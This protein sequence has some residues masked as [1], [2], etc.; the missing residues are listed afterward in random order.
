[1]TFTNPSTN[2]F[3][4][5]LIGNLSGKHLLKHKFYQAWSEGSLSVPTL[6]LYAQQYYHH[7]KAF[8]RY[9]SATHS[10]C[11]NIEA[12][13]FLLENL[14]DEEK[15]TEH[16]PELWLRFAEG[17]GTTR[18]QVKN[19]LPLPETQDLVDTFFSSCRK[20]YA[21]GLGT[22]FAY[23]HQIP[24][25][26]TFKIEALQKHYG[27]EE[28]S[29][30]LSFFEVHRQADVFHT[31]TIAQLLDGLTPAEKTLAEA[32]AHTA[33]DR[34]WKFLDGITHTLSV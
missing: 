16:H 31:Q 2:S 5:Q 10:N 27:I 1:M 32:A 3:T 22:L 19:A 18:D 7:V 21:E 29:S 6:Q 14:N 20:S 25:V 30:T 12:R 15:G 8:P 34:L 26:A 23:E 4:H 13:Q 33:T 9:I 28:G 17:M 24:E 11:E